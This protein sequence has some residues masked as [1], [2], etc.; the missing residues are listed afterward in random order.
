[1]RSR[2]EHRDGE[3]RD[4]C[5]SETEAPARDAPAE[6]PLREYEVDGSHFGIGGRDL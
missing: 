6:P 1:M 2:R 3:R 5:G 4:G